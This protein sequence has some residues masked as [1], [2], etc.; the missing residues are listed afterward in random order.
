MFSEVC[1]PVITSWLET[2]KLKV[3]AKSE[4]GHSNTGHINTAETRD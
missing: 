1:S 3:P 4:P 2:E